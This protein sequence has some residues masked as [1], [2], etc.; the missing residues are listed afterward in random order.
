MAS[1]RLAAL[2]R[3]DL[4]ESLRYVAEHSGAENARR[5]RRQIRGR[6]PLLAEQPFMGRARPEFGRDLRSFPVEG[7]VI[8]YRPTGYGVE[9]VRVVHGSRDIE[10]LFEQ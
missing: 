9:I 1:Y 4:R 10:A 3:A 5:L 6:F 2:A 8:I 7:F